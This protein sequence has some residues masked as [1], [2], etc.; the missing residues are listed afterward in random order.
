MFT[1]KALNNTSV[2]SINKS[3]VSLYSPDRIEMDQVFE[4]L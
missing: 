1:L 4:K 2:N 3:D